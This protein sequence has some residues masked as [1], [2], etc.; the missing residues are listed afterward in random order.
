MLHLHCSPCEWRPSGV[1]NILESAQPD[2]EF[3]N[4]DHLNFIMMKLLSML[5]SVNFYLHFKILSCQDRN[6]CDLITLDYE[7]VASWI[8]ET[9]DNTEETVM[10][11][12]MGE[13][14]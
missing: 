10:L 6:K 5:R 11:W 4:F 2:L 3:A 1:N 7:E 9:G 13:N 14:I 8:V 12:T